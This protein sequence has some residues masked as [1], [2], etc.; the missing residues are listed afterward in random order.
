MAHAC[1]GE[2]VRHARAITSDVR[3]STPTPLHLARRMDSTHPYYR[4]TAESIEEAPDAAEDGNTAQEE[5]TSL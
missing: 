5:T 2:D 4:R 1:I 3:Q